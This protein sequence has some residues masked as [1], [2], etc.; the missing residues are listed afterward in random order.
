MKPYWVRFEDWE[1]YQNGMYSSRLDE[2]IAL[3]C[4]DL[5]KSENLYKKMIAI[6]NDYPISSKVNLN[7]TVFNRNAWIGQATCNLW[8]KATIEETTWAW[9]RLSDRERKIANEIAEQVIKE[10]HNETLFT[11][12]CV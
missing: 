9:V 11:Y 7:K 5:F 6:L 2:S 3:K 4:I 1:D 8:L 10:Y 12:E